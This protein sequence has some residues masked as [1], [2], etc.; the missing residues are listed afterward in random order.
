MLFFFNLIQALNSE[1]HEVV[2]ARWRD[3]ADSRWQPG[4]H[5]RARSP[6]VK[7]P[8]VQDVRSV[9]RFARQPPLGDNRARQTDGQ[10]LDVLGVRPRC[11]QAHQHQ[12]AGIHSGDCE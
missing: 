3:H 9:R 11:W 12:A 6:L 2:A 4:K 10:A 5:P 8:G 1:N 7:P